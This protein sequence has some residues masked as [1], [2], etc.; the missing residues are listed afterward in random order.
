M[1]GSFLAGTTGDR[2]GYAH[3]RTNGRSSPAKRRLPGV[4][5]GG[6]LEPVVER[7]Q[8]GLGA[9]SPGQSELDQAIGEPGVLGQERT[10]E[11]GTDHVRPPHPLQAIGAVVAVAPNHPAQGLGT[12]AQVRPPPVVLEAGQLPG[13]L[14]QVDLDLDVADQPRAWL[15]HRL[16][17]GEA[18]AGDPIVAQLVAVAEELVTAAN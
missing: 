3:A 10:V 12:V 16:Q 11:V 6:C 2:G 7:R 5:V 15:A 17:L 9:V 1:T 14:A 4:L 18:E 13:P 8:L